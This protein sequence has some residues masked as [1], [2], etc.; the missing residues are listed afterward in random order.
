MILGLG[1]ATVQHLDWKSRTDIFTAGAPPA[2][3]TTQTVIAQTRNSLPDGVTS[4]GLIDLNTAAVEVLDSLPGI[5]PAK[6]AAIVNYRA[7]HGGF[8]SVQELANVKGISAAM[9]G[10]L[11]PRLFAG[12]VL[13]EKSLMVAAQPAQYPQAVQGRIQPAAP[14]PANRV[15]SPVQTGMVNINTATADQLATLKHIGPKLAQN[16]IEYRSLHGAFPAVEALDAV[17]GIGP[18][19]IEE[20]RGRMTVR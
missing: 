17:K 2:A 10:Q 14:L 6:A 18:H 7:E 9:A 5:G 19:I 15:A 12:N 3:A 13:P 20:N 1:G 11:A 4:S 16:I 8:R